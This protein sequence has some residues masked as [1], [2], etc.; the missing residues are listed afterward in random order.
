ME[1][2]ANQPAS[3][4]RSDQSQTNGMMACT[5]RSFYRLGGAECILESNMDDLS[6]FLLSSV[7]WWWNKMERNIYRFESTDEV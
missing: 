5:G 7:A 2:A 6:R 1:E 4:L 3:Q